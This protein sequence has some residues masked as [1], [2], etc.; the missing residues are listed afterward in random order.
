M[1]FHSKF[2]YIARECSDFAAHLIPLKKK[3]SER[4]KVLIIR[5]DNIGDFILWLDSFRAYSQIFPPDEYDVT[6]LGNSVW[7]EL[8]RVNLSVKEFLF[9][10]P[11]R[12]C[13]NLAYRW[14]IFKQ[15][16]KNA[17][18]VVV[19]AR[20]SKRFALE[21]AIIRLCGAYQRIGFESHSGSLRQLE[22]RR[23][24]R[25]YSHLIT[26]S[27]GDVHEL[28]RNGE[29]VLSLGGAKDFKISTPKLHIS[30]Q[31]DEEAKAII[32]EDGIPSDYYVLFIGAA[33]A[34]K[35]WPTD[36]YIDIG[37]LLY[38]RY[39][40]FGV[41]CGGPEDADA[42]KII[43]READVPMRNLAGRTSL[44]VLA[45]VI[46]HAKL[47]VTNDTLAVHMAAALSIPCVCILGGGHFGRFL[48]YP[49]CLGM[50]SQIPAIVYKK[51]ECF[52]CNWHCIHKRTSNSQPFPCVSNITVEMVWSA[53]NTFLETIERDPQGI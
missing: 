7:E 15:L 51:M 18:D 38:K 10:N 36:R 4:Q 45:A 20:F 50:S 25:W 22:E 5:L 39:G 48:P 21:D 11:N 52:G 42:G 46:K 41:I 47:L 23:S 29:F 44:N 8:A 31:Q 16:R 3:I 9:I 6:V 13:S 27:L 1:P 49:A 32:A 40:W 35:R 14:E 30:K 12:F 17:F 53:I 26:T 34:G 28:Q 24:R 33:E 2:L 43:L 37:K 19:Q